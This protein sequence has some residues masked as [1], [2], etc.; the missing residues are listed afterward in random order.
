MRKYKQI[1]E[2]ERFVIYKCLKNKES[3]GTIA[4]VLL[5]N[6][7]S[8]SRE[9]K[10]N[11]LNRYLG[12]LPDSAQI[13]SAKRKARHNH[14]IDR[15][16]SL[17]DYMINGLLKKWSPETIAGRMK[18]EKHRVTISHE[19]IY[20]YIYEAGGKKLGL[21]RL[22]VN[23]RAKR[24]AHYSRKKRTCGIPDRVSI[25]QRPPIIGSRKEFGHLEGDLTFFK[26]HRSQNLSVLVE[27][28]SRF[29]FLVKNTSKA[30]RVV[31][32]GIERIIGTNM[33]K[34]FKSITFDNGSEF[35]SH[36]RLKQ[37][38]VE[39]YFCDPGS[40]W[41][42]GQVERSIAILHR[43]LPKNTDPGT[44][45]NEVLSRV[46]DQFNCLP[47]KCLRFMTPA[48]VFYS[49]FKSVALQT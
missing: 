9:I 36:N 2:Q 19:S 24:R 48:E 16:G 21:Y 34:T 45:S 47:R 39:T 40:P 33:P 6:K 38:L 14:K 7:S 11:T 23:G 43:F 4:K 44:L 29:L 35:S 8:I 22:L 10:R 13:L 15:H 42:K 3:I 5:R 46:A 49:K 18:R 28:Q 37:K 1:S 12:Y 27:K 31:I 17:K 30:T 41:Q 20:Q 26:N 32:D 25:H